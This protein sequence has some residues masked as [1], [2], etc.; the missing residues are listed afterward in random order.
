[1]QDNERTDELNGEPGIPRAGVPTFGGS[2][3]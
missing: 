3:P 1:L 2:G